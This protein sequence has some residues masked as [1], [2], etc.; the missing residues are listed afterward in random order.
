MGQKTR[1]NL[2]KKPVTPELRT[3]VPIPAKQ[4]KVGRALSDVAQTFL[5]RKEKKT[6]ET[7][8]HFPS[9]TKPLEFPSSHYGLTQSTE[10]T[11][12]LEVPVK[13]KIK[14]LGQLH[15]TT[16]KTEVVLISLKCYL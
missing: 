14:A 12:G 4:L 6:C 10:V 3:V 1:R 15:R 11:S 16:G 5:W 9:C 2:S 7:T 8:K 13:E